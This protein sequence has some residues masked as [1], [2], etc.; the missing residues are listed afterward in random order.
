MRPFPSS[1]DKTLYWELSDTY[2]EEMSRGIPFS[3]N[4][5]VKCF[6]YCSRSPILISLS[7]MS[8]CVQPNGEENP[9]PPNLHASKSGGS[10]AE[11]GEASGSGRRPPVWTESQSQISPQKIFVSFLAR[12]PCSR[13]KRRREK[14]AHKE[15]E[16]RQQ[17]TQDRPVV[18]RGGRPG[19]D[20]NAGSAVSLSR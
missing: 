12:S 4:K 5:Q 17:P 2:Q 19:I 6:S 18:W 8:S 13:M 16:R 10:E 9:P 7:L 1:Q 3:K 14:A 15:K 20:I 11:E